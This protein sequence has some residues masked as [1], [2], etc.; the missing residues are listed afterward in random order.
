MPPAASAEITSLEPLLVFF[1]DDHHCCQVK[2]GKTLIITTIV[3]PKTSLLIFGTELTTIPGK[4]R[5][6]IIMHDIV[7]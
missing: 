3:Y 1:N 5:I 6:K 4:T 7:T 2:Y